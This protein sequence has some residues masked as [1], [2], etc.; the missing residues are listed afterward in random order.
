MLDSPTNPALS[1]AGV[2]LTEIPTNRACEVCDVLIIYWIFSPKVNVFLLEAVVTGL[3]GL[4]LNNWFDF[5][6]QCDNFSRNNDILT[7]WKLRPCTRFPA[8]PVQFI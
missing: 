7:F 1:A 2:L 4:I 3:P 8:E 5:S 6:Q